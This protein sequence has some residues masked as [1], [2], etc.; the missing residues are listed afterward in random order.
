MNKSTCTLALTLLT[1]LGLVTVAKADKPKSMSGRSVTIYT[2]PPRDN[3]N[4]NVIV[5]PYAEKSSY[6]HNSKQP[7]YGHTPNTPLYQNNYR[8]PEY[9]ENIRYSSPNKYKH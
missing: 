9:Q 8:K 7:S 1:T 6:P 3:T 4:V 5:H 2:L